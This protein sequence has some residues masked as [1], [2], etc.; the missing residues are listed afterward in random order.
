M[1]CSAAKNITVEP[2][3]GNKVTD[4]SSLSNGS[5]RKVSIPKSVPD[6]PPLEGED[7]QTEVLESAMVN[8]LQKG[9]N[10]LSF[11]IAF[12]ED[13]DGESIIKKHPPKRFQKL[14]EQQTSPTVTLV[15]L[16]EKLEEAEIRR[17]QI[18]QQRVQ[19]AKYRNALK[20]QASVSSI[21][22]EH[23]KVPTEVAPQTTNSYDVSYV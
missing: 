1:G 10:G 19:S 20:K 15:K 21:D 22:D 7:P 2:L 4:I 23:L 13:K 3:N 6:V 14:E 11:E 8:N 9:S 18:L 5:V 16:Q 12:E 17:Q